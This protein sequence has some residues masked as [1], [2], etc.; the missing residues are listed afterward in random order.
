[1]DLCWMPLSLSSFF[2]WPLRLLTYRVHWFF[3]A[4]AV[5]RLTSEFA[6]LRRDS[7]DVIRFLYNFLCGNI[8]ETSMFSPY[9][10]N[11]PLWCIKSASCLFTAIHHDA[12]RKKSSVI[13]EEKNKETKSFPRGHWYL[14][15]IPFTSM[16]GVKSQ[17]ELQMV[18]WCDRQIR[19]LSCGARG[20]RWRTALSV[21][22]S[23]MW[24]W[25]KGIS[26]A[27]AAVVWFLD[28]HTSR[29]WALEDRNFVPG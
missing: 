8:W 2:Q 29:L 18:E 12:G 13:K 25:P 11:I 27:E 14:L 16:W 6:W 4:R 9:G 10:G 22:W 1:M 17:E 7:F 21:G 26:D 28:R 24:D 19:V 23:A 5:H 3:H 20:I 15:M